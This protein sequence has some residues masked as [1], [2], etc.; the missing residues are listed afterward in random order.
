MIEHEQ[1][2]LQNWRLKTLQEAQ[3]KRRVVY[4]H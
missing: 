1:Q 4:E 2:R 3:G